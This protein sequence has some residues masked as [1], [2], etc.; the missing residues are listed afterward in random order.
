MDDR[1]A[2]TIDD[3]LGFVDRTGKVVIPPRFEGTS[4]FSEGLA[5]VR[6]NGKWSFIDRGGKVISP[7]FD[8]AGNFSEELAPVNMN[9]KW[10]FIDKTGKVAI[11]PQFE[12]VGS[13]A[14]VD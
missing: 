6:I 14:K 7:E 8:S 10:G 9:G 5:A 11:P 3:G 1:A 2:V 4:N 12:S 13:F